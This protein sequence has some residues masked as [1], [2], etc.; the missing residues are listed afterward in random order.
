MG[1]FDKVVI[2]F[3]NFHKLGDSQFIFLIINGGA[4][5]GTIFFL[6]RENCTI[7]LSHKILNKIL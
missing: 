3:L 4:R 5:I 7:P 2:I 6:Y 1:I